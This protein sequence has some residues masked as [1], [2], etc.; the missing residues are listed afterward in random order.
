MMNVTSRWKSRRWSARTAG[1]LN[2]YA[3]WVGT[4]SRLR[5]TERRYGRRDV[6]TRRSARLH[7][8]LR[9]GQAGARRLSVAAR[10]GPRLSRRETP[11]PLDLGQIGRA[12]CRERGEIGVRAAL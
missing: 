10:L 8:G 4:A 2:G 11:V 7:P 3:S 9:P 6:T 5:E 12:S 1:I